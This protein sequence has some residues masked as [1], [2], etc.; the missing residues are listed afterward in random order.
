MSLHSHVS[1]QTSPISMLTPPALNHVH[2]QPF[3]AD[4]GSIGCVGAPRSGTIFASLRRLFAV[5]N[6]PLT[7]FSPNFFHFAAGSTS[8]YLAAGFSTAA[9]R[10]LGGGHP[11]Q[12]LPYTHHCVLDPYYFSMRHHQQR[13]ECLSFHTILISAL[14]GDLLRAIFVHFVLGRRPY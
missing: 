12:P 14:G 9:L 5:F 6:L 13:F 1:L 7:Y 3:P 2:S 8:I 10:R 11:V 4:F